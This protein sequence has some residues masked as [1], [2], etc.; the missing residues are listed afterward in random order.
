MK[1]PR[2]GGSSGAVKRA[3]RQRKRL[4]EAARD[5]T[6]PKSHVA[7]KALKNYATKHKKK[8]RKP[9]ARIKGGAKGAAYRDTETHPD[10]YGPQV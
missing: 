1:I 6:D 4:T 9:G 10:R 8:K 5:V 2:K 7:A 3:F